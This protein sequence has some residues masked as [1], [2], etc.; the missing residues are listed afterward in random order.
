MEPDGNPNYAGKVL[1][2][3]VDG[4][5]AQPAPGQPFAQAPYVF[6]AGFRNPAA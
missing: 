3:S 4:G 2:M 5:A 6:G 1:R